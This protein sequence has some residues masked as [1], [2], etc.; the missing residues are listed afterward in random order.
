MPE[1]QTITL[2][3]NKI[4]DNT[5]EKCTSLAR[6]EISDKVVNIGEYAFRG[7]SF[8]QDVSISES[9]KSIGTC[10]F[11]DTEWL[12]ANNEDFVIVGD[13]V[14]I[15]YNG[16][17]SNVTIPNNTKKIVDAF[18]DCDALKSVEL[19]KQKYTIWDKIIYFF[20]NL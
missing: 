9:V 10:A 7:C 11:E 2:Q 20:K 6:I 15:K 4:L 5:F 1:N 12:S 18:F 14:L 13:G 16:T 3:I 19:K 8:L 17:E